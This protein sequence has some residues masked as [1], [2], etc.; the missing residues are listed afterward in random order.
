MA[1]SLVLKG[2]KDVKKQKGSELLLTR[3]K[4][5]GDF[6]QVKK[7]WN[8]SPNNTVYVGCS[9]F[10][11]TTGSGVAYLAID[12]S[13]MSTIRIDH[14]GSFNFSFYIFA[15]VSRAAL[16][17]EDWQIIEH[18][19]FPKIAKGPVTTVIPPGAAPKPS[20]APPAPPIGTVTII[21]DATANDSDV[22]TYSLTVSGG[23]TDLDYAWSASG[24]A[25]PNIGADVTAA[26][27]EF[28]F[29]TGASTVECQVTSPTANDSPVTG[30]LDVNTTLLF[31]TLVNNADLSVAVTVADTGNGDKYQIDGVE[32]DGI[33]ATVGSTI[34][35]DMSDASTAGHPIAIYTDA[36]K[37]TLVTVGIETDENSN[38]LIFTPPIAGTFSYQCTQHA[39][40]GG[41]ITVS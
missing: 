14:D 27:C 29:S 13:E 25:T 39:A 37:T 9:V 21:G 40:M 38:D 41:T 10:K 20:P 3:P 23:A 16:F 7:W 15:Q 5:G 22:K 28:L 34:H 11:V 18:Y 2:A 36:S 33:V 30:T 26:T 8:T 35:F 12:T 4:R 31:S 19:M 17:T 6:H 1:D 24:N 32:Q